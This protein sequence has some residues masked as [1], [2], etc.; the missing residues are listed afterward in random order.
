MEQN[1]NRKHVKAILKPCLRADDDFT[2]DKP[3]DDSATKD[4]EP[5]ERCQ[6]FKPG[7]RG[8]WPLRTAGKRAGAEQAA[9]HHVPRVGGRALTAR[10]RGTAVSA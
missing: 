9:T 5:I 6:K 8:V 1:F 3:T 4:F 2:T 10:P 7:K